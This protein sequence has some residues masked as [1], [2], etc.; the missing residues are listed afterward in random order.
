MM[1]KS[2][3]NYDIMK[4]RMSA[5]FLKYD[6]EHMIQKF[7]LPYDEEYIYLRF[8]GRDYRIS[9]NHGNVQ[10]S[11]DDFKTVEEANY[12]EAM[13]IYDVL[14][15]SKENCRLSGK[16]CPVNMLKG[17]VQTAGERGSFFQHT[18]DLFAGKTSILQNAM[19]KIGHK[20]DLKGDVT[21][22]IQVF[23]FFPVSFQFWDADEEFRAV[24][25]FM[26]DENT[27]DF[28]HFETV[29]FMLTHVLD[30]IK[31]CMEED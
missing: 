2:D 18:A 25:K 13:T 12:N 1:K 24:L 19:E 11:E 31:E 27:L 21:A 26:V 14:C 28:M 15:Y 3:S 16:F 6:Q 22:R 17:L 5:E 20:T 23:D 10:W 7:S 9:R 8:V 29:M 30:R 4:N